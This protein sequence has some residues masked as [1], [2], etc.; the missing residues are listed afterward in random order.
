MG[1]YRHDSVVELA[2][3]SDVLSSH[4]CGEVAAFFDVLY[5]RAARQIPDPLG[6]DGRSPPPLN[7]VR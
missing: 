4:T 6:F 5:H 7:D 3:F 1:R 2:D